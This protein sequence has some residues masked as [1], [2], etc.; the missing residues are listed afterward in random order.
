MNADTMSF[1]GGLALLREA[2]VVLHVR[3]CWPRGAAAEPL[4]TVGQAA[5]HRTAPHGIAPH[6]I[7]PHR[8]ASHCTAPHRIAP[9]ECSRWV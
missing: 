2:L 9:R 1:G 6:R 5:P 7:A 8:T 4:R 3:A